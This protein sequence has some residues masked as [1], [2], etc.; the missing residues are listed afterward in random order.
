MTSMLSSSE[1]CI[2]SLVSCMPPWKGAANQLFQLSAEENTV[3]RRKLRR[4]QSSVRLF[5]MGVPETEGRAA[6]GGMA[7]VRAPRHSRKTRLPLDCDAWGGS[8]QCAQ[9]RT[10]HRCSLSAPVLRPRSLRIPR[11]HPLRS[12]AHSLTRHRRRRRRLTREEQPVLRVIVRDDICE[13]R[14]A[15]LHPMAFV[16]DD[17]VPTDLVEDSLVA[18]D[19][20]VVREEHVESAV[21]EDEIFQIFP[22]V[23]VSVVHDSLQ[24]WGPLP[25]RVGG[26]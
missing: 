11:R 5:W 7:S 21:A 14:I 2:S 19:E 24:V 18:D 23:L 17:V 15:I 12:L 3:G 25:A 8:A 16:H 26:G 20:V 13:L 4:A 9:G 1:S 10:A 6:Q 22:V